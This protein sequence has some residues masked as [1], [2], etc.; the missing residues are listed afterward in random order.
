MSPIQCNLINI[1]QRKSYGIPIHFNLKSTY[2]FSIY[3][4]LLKYR[5]KSIP[6]IPFILKIK[7]QK[8][9]KKRIITEK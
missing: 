8:L 9:E 4:I 2:P 5:K 3:I 1:S 7:K 6:T